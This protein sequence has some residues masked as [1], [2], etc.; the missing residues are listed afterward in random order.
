MAIPGLGVS[1]D[2][3]DRRT[4]YP[5]R[6]RAALF[7]AIFS[8]PAR[9]PIHAHRLKFREIEAE[10]LRDERTQGFAIRQLRGFGDTVADEVDALVHDVDAAF[11]GCGAG[12]DVVGEEGSRVRSGV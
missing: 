9:H 4:K 12:E 11:S 5:V 3:A 6:G 8:L 1:L 7:S 2:H 10:V